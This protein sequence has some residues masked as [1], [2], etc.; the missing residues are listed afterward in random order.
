MRQIVTRFK[1]MCD[2]TDPSFSLAA[3]P[4]QRLNQIW[5]TS[6][7]LDKGSETAERL[8][9]DHRDQSDRL[10]DGQTCLFTI[11]YLQCLAGLNWILNVVNC[12]IYLK[13]EPGRSSLRWEPSSLHTADGWSSRSSFY[14][15]LQV[16]LTTLP[17][18]FP[19]TAVLL[20][21]FW[22]NHIG[23]FYQIHFGL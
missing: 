17:A 22:P 15:L 5:Q 7:L 16:L 3:C 4:H 23:I 18:L 19:V 10:Q 14:Q 6:G 11:C 8:L 2:D 20:Y 12:I 1:T 13:A 9:Y 21:C